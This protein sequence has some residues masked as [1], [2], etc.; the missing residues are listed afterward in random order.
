M[1]SS[2]TKICLVIGD[3]IEH[4]L[5]PL[6]HNAG[7]KA[8]GIEDEFVFLAA[9]VK[10]KD[11]KTAVKAVRALG[12][13]GLTCTIPHKV[14]AMRYLDKIDK[15][16]KEIGAVNTIVNNKGILTGY[17]TDW[18]GALNPLAKKSGVKGKRIGIIGAGGAAR[19]IIFG[20]KKSGGKIKIFNKDIKQAKKLAKRFACESGG[21]GE[22]EQLKDFDIIVNATPLGMKPCENISPVPKEFFSKNQI[23]FDIVYNPYKT[24]MLKEAEKRG[25]KII[26]GIEMFLG[27]GI[28]QFTYYTNRKAPFQAMRKAVNNFLYGG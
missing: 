6:M 8:L 24:K 28:A 27:Q 18:L 15:A 22:L 10:P 2:K 17:N 12:I 5:S 3:P 16:V 19:A 11:L 4:S 23:V 21:F 14:E 9:R 20:L 13:R 7:Y 25:A 26:P 1:F